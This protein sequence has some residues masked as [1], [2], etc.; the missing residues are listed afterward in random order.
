MPTDKAGER[1]KTVLRFL[2]AYGLRPVEIQHLSIHADDGRLWCD[3]IKRSGKGE[4]DPRVLKPLHEEWEQ[5]W[6]LLEQV[7][8]GL[9]LPPFGGGVAN[10]GRRYLTRQQGWKPLEAKGVTMYSF[11]HGYALRAH[12]QYGLSARIAARVM[13]H[14]VQTHNENY[15]T[16]ADVDEIDKAYEAG[17]RYRQ[18]L[19]G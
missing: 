4:T 13:G 12:Q 19:K 15:G 9:D 1:W 17:K 11:R 16:W 3:Y 8:N 7:A 6:G 18:R 10:A 2:A 5:E 14:S